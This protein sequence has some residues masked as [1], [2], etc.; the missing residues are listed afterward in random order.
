MQSRRML[1]DINGIS[2][3]VFKGGFDSPPK[4]SI[5]VMELM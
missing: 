5:K 3:M 1:I 4:S 2:Y